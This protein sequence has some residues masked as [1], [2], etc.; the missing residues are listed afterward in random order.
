M[1]YIPLVQVP[2]SIA[3]LLDAP[4]VTPDRSQSASFSLE[5]IGENGVLAPP[6]NCVQ[7]NPINIVISQDAAGGNT[8][9][10]SSEYKFSGDYK[11][12]PVGASEQVLL[13]GLITEVTPGGVATEITA[14]LTEG[15]V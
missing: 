11:T 1:S 7:G 4:V 2:D 8:L 5:L 9:T 14:V 13:S 6:E 3:V 12:I 15:L 10:F